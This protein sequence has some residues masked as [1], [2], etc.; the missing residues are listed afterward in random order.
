MCPKLPMHGTRSMAKRK[1]FESNC[2]LVL[3]AAYQLMS[4]ALSAEEAGLMN[5]LETPRGAGPTVNQAVAGLQNCKCAD[6]S[7]VNI[8][9]KHLA[10]GQKLDAISQIVAFLDR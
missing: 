10:A 8:L 5:Y 6:Q 7:F 1:T 3:L 2:R 4:F 9:S